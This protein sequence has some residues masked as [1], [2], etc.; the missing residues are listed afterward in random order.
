MKMNT[1]LQLLC[2]N[3]VLGVGRLHCAPAS[4]DGGDG[5]SGHESQDDS[6]DKTKPASS[7]QQ[8]TLP[9]SDRPQVLAPHLLGLSTEAEAESGALRCSLLTLDT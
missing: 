6:R 4:L 1:L 8:V 9:G 5:E 7:S 2:L 3:T